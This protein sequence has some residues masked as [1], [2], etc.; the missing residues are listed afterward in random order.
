MTK[1]RFMNKHFMSDSEEMRIKMYLTFGG[2]FYRTVAARVYGKGNPNY[3]P[4]AAEIA[5]VGKIARENNM[6]STDWRRGESESASR[7]LNRMGRTRLDAKP[8]L[9]IAV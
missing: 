8:K 4:S 5:R 6:S 9:R 2:F 1:K 7:L 3:E